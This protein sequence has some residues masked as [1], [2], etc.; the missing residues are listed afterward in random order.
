M[1]PDVGCGGRGFSAWLAEVGARGLRV[2]L[3]LGELSRQGAPFSGPIGFPDQPRRFSDRE[4]KDCGVCLEKLPTL[5][6]RIGRKAPLWD[7]CATIRRIISWAAG[8]DE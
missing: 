2:L 6:Q 5:S 1:R 8:K 7:W 3:A 4:G